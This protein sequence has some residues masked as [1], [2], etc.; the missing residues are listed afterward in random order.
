M[1]ENRNQEMDSKIG[2]ESMNNGWIEPYLIAYDHD[3]CVLKSLHHLTFQNINIP[4]Y[5]YQN[6]QLT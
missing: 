3:L 1:I 6:M 2:F 5:S 4:Y